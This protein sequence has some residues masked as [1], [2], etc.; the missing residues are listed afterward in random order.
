LLWIYAPPSE[1]SFQI[2]AAPYIAVDRHSPQLCCRIIALALALSGTMMVVPEVHIPI[3]L[4]MVA[5]ISHSVRSVAPVMPLMPLMMN[6]LIAIAIANSD[7]SK[8]N[9]HGGL[10]HRRTR[11]RG[12]QERK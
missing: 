4:L 8:I 7:V 9:A 2:Q 3:V 1:L 10:C 6:V 12:S 5:A 11:G